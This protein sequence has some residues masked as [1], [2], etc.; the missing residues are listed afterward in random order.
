[1]D[2]E[3]SQPL[4]SATRFL[5]HP[6]LL[7]LCI[8]CG[9]L[10]HTSDAA[11]YAWMIASGYAKC[12]TCHVDPSGGE[13]LTHM[14][15]VQS[16]LLLSQRWSPSSE[17]SPNVRTAYGLDEPDW[18]RAGGSA[19]VLSI[20]TLP[21]GTADPELVAFPMQADVYATASFGNL[22]AGASVGYADVPEASPHAR[23]AE[24][25][26]SDAGPALL[27]RWHWLG[28]E[29]DDQ[30]LLRAG[31]INLPFGVRIPEHVM[32]A[33]DA[34]KTDRESDQQHGVAL[35]GWRRTWRW[36]LMGVAGN[37]Q[38][39][40][41]AV[42]E[43]GYSGYLEHLFNA[44]LAL[45]ASSM[46]LWSKES[47]LTGRTEPTWRQAHG[48]MGR[49]SPFASLGF[50]LEVD[51]LSTTGRKPGYVG[52]A[53]V[54]YEPEQG[55]HL[56][57]TAE[58]LDAG[59]LDDVPEFLSGGKP[60]SGGWLTIHWFFL[61]HWDLQLDWVARYEQSKTMQAQLHFYL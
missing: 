12:A 17:V 29:F 50:L 20:F 5:W 3:R 42:R 26:R 56:R 61:P 16:Q 39:R 19:R 60:T 36:E 4:N 25:F 13:T 14:G 21:R 59:R 31:R 11:A 49:Y 55:L 37:L 44:R 32:W 23:P 1:V 58:I 51:F 54:D 27:S 52:F 6:G 47:I 48:L 34:T 53:T 45:G 35:A 41:D 15:R 24:V 46:G 40:P 8:A 18:L 28:V 22:R 33:R 43:R 10:T 57:A 30:L 7:W 38:L 9:V 2:R